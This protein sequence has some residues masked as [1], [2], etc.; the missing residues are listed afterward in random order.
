MIK[1]GSQQAWNPFTDPSATWNKYSFRPSDA[2]LGY[3]MISIIPASFQSIASIST[4]LNEFPYVKVMEYFMRNNVSSAIN[5]FQG[6]TEGAESEDSKEEN[7]PATIKDNAKSL[8][9]LVKEKFAEIPLPEMQVIHI[10]FKLYHKLKA[11]LYGNTYVFPYI[12]KGN[13]ITVSS[14]D[15]E[16]N[17]NGGLLSGIQ[18]SLLGAANGITGMLGVGVAK[19]FPAPTWK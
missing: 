9:D 17:E 1:D 8:I 4:V 16:W 12:P 10:P 14:N 13:P 18:N 3:P 19:P 6:L 5:L 11:K 7:Q 2:M 15:S